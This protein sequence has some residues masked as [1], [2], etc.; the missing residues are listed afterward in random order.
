M[1]PA[2]LP[3]GAVNQP[4]CAPGPTSLPGA[5]RPQRAASEDAGSRLRNPPGNP[6]QRLAGRP[7]SR[8]RVWGLL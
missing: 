7:A 4:R 5:A 6:G 8:S 1:A 2:W 3:V